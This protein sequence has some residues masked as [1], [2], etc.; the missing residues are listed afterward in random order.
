MGLINPHEYKLSGEVQLNTGVPVLDESLGGYPGDLP[1][2][3]VGYSG[4]GKT[5]LALQLAGVAANRD[6]PCLFVTSES[7]E[8]VYS[9]AK[10]IIPKFEELF[11]REQFV[12]LEQFSS[13]PYLLKSH[14]MQAYVD[15]LTAQHAQAKVWVLDSI[16]SLFGDIF[17]LDQIRLQ[18][19]QLVVLAKE[20][21]SRIVFTLSEESAVQIPGLKRV[22][23][24]LAGAVISLNDHVTSG[25]ELIVNKSR[26]TEPKRSR[27]A[28]G[29]KGSG[30]VP[31][32]VM[33]DSNRGQSSSNQNEFPASTRLRTTVVTSDK[34]FG[35]QLVRSVKNHLVLS[36][37]NDVASAFEQYMLQGPDML[38]LDAKSKSDRDSIFRIINALRAHGSVVPIIVLTQFVGRS[39]DRLGFIAR[40]ATAVMDRNASPFELLHKIHTLSHHPDWI[41]S[42]VLPQE[43][44]LATELDDVPELPSHFDSQWR[45]ARFLEQTLG[46][47]STMAEVTVAD[48]AQLA[49]VQSIMQEQIRDEDAV[50]QIAENRMK[51]LLGATQNRVAAEVVQRRLEKNMLELLPGLD[52]GLEWHYH[53]LSEGEQKPSVSNNAKDSSIQTSGTDI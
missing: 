14:Q 10:A 4:T 28:F 17:C 24:D 20:R 44:R 41:T 7:G 43:Q 3:I 39:L 32:L 21:G 34:E 53:G 35:K 50:V 40:G 49:A 36:L 38:I 16:D 23:S 19:Q 29:I 5:V 11:D 25:R 47:E 52:R 45:R 15:A 37:V 42:P 9:Q 31:I 26:I 12:L 2:T 22:L 13:A 30:L 8:A 33:A 27:I 1:L 46:V 6:E 48:K 18:L 51:L